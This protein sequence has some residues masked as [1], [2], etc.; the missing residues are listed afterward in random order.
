MIIKVY[1][2]NIASNPDFLNIIEIPNNAINIYLIIRK[3]C[4]LNPS[5]TVSPYS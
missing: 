3:S 5:N 2:K 1:I 4:S